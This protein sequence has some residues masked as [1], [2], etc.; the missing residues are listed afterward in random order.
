[1]RLL[2]AIALT[3][4]LTGCKGQP[5]PDSSPDTGPTIRTVTYPSGKDRVKGVLYRPAGEGPFA[6]VVVVHGDFGLTPWVKDQGRRLAKW[7]YIALAV[8]LYR[9]E[10]PADLMEAHILD[11][12]LP[13][14]RVLADL[15]GAVSYLA[16]R[17]D[18]RRGKLGIIGWDSGGGYALDVALKDRRLKAVV[19]CYGRLTTDPKLLA[20]LRASVLGIF[21][22]DDE[23]ITPE[24][25]A[26]FRA[27]LRKA[28]KR[29]AGLHVYRECGHGFMT[30]EGSARPA[31]PVTRATS[32]A[33][34]KIEAF[35]GEEL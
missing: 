1:M 26:Q 34:K 8:D 25:I 32:D 12:G 27:A 9:G 33:W 4:F 20:P 31:P 10:I 15:K 23:G 11:R 19:T 7:G 13:D 29:N 35:L 6:A 28:D 2:S 30:P 3:L 17:S 21:A 16:G 5:A 18:V 22:G 14:E 24:T